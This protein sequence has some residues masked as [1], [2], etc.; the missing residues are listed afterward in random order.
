VLALL[1]LAAF[2]V[3]TAV[4]LRR[5]WPLAVAAVFLIA[6]VVKLVQAGRERS[7]Q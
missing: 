2:W 3:V 1:A 4:V 5:T 7:V 6:L